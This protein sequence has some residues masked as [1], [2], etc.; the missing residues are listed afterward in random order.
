MAAEKMTVAKPA[1]AQMK[2][3]INRNVL[4]PGALLGGLRPPNPRSISQLWIP[5]PPMLTGR[6][7][8][9]LVTWLS[10]PTLNGGPA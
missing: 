10:S 2:M 6:P 4:K 9:A 5:S 7:G 1:E 3:T 8:I